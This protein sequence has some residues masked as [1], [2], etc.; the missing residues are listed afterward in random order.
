MSEN[1]LS[2]KNLHYEIPYGKVIIQDFSID[3]Y[4]GEFV[5][6]LGK[7]GQGKTSLIELILGMRTPTSGSIK[8]FGKDFDEEVRPQELSFLSYDIQLQ[9]NLTVREFLNFNASFYPKYS[10]GVETNYLRYFQID[11]KSKIASFSTGGQK[12]VQIVAALSSRPKLLIIDE[13]TAVLDPNSR[14]LLFQALIHEQL[15]NKLTIFLATNI[16]EDLVDRASKILYI[17]HT[18]VTEHQ[19]HNILELFASSQL[20]DNNA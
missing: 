2:I 4:S 8:I 11:E 13:I 17:D 9:G 19:S 1:I 18:S 15:E 6:L 20:G 12:K 16:A 3:I 7:N 14:A 5:G 10:K